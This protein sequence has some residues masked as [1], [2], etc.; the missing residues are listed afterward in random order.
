MAGDEGPA[1]LVE[2]K[3]VEA[4]FTMLLTT[5][6]EPGPR[7]MRLS[8]VASLRTCEEEQE[9]VEKRSLARDERIR[10]TST[11]TKPFCG[12]VKEKLG[13]NSKELHDRRETKKCAYKI[14][15]LLEHGKYLFLKG[16]QRRF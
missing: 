3:L 6:G 15:A 12:K 1:T 2:G 16:E 9:T 7:S 5:A 4:A 10:C 14:I 11:E 8:S 13:Y